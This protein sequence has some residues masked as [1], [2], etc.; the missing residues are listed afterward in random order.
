MTI[1]AVTPKQIQAAAL[2]LAKIK[3]KDVT[4]ANP[5]EAMAISWAESFAHHGLEF[6]DLMAGVHN[7]FAD[8]T[9]P[10]DRVLPADIIRMAREVRRDRIERDP[11]AKRAIEDGIDAKISRR[12]REV[13]ERPAVESRPV[14]A[15]KLEVMRIAQEAAKRG[16]F[17]DVD[18]A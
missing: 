5:D 17:R 8:P 14:S 4:A 18:T 7:W 12:E 11:A 3:T 2:V 13:A 16:V 1:P 15:A 9:R 10:R 6:S